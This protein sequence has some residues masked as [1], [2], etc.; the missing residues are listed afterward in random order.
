MRTVPIGYDNRY[1][2]FYYK[3]SMAK[4]LTGFNKQTINLLGEMVRTDFKLRYQNSALGYLWSLL[5]PLFLFTI[6]YVV[7][8]MI[9]GI[10]EGI[11]A[12]GVYKLIGVLLWSF[13][14]ES[15]NRSVTSITGKS[16][17]IRKISIPKY[18][19]VLA[20]VLNS[21]TNF[22]LSSVIIIIFMI[23]VPDVEVTFSMFPL[24]LLLVVQL[25]VI[26]TSISF[27]LSAMF[28]RFR[29]I[30]Y[31]WEV[32]AQGLFYGSGVIFP[33]QLAP[34]AIRGLLLLN[35]IAQIIHDIRR[36]LVY[37][38]TIQLYDVVAWPLWAVPFAITAALAVFAVFYFRKQSVTFAEDL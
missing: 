14:S 19:V 8:T 26:A 3:V 2:L 15:T 32:I 27:I 23:V 21:F 10:G 31:I 18:L 34:E 20:S 25:F 12:Y 36:I 16:S 4:I 5:K 28:V 6:L 17:L 9:L 13:F 29:D 7:F 37:P 24:L 33:L 1:H 35:P 30:S 11:P 22:L 38:G